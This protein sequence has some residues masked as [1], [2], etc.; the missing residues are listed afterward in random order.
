[1]TRELRSGHAIPTLRFR[2]K[3]LRWFDQHKRDLPWR[4]D[5]NPY[6]IWVSEIMLQQTRVAAVLGYYKRFI[7][8]F[9]TFERLAAAKQSSVLAAWSGLGYYRRAR[10]LHAAAKEIVYE[11]SGRFPTTAV[12]LQTLPGVGRYTSA[13]I[14][15]IAFN[16]PAAVVDGNV[17]RVLQRVLGKNID[18]TNLWQ[19]AEDLLSRRRPGDFNQAM[20]E[21]GATL[22]LPRRPKCLLCPISNICITRGEGELS[23]ASRPNHQNKRE[24]C[25]ALD[26]RNGSV[27]LVKRNKT[28]ELMPEMWELPEIIRASGPV[29]AC[30]TLGHSITVTN[31][32]VHVVR[33]ELP[34]ETEGCWVPK[35]RIT[36]LP[37]TGLTQKILRAAKVI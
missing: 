16:E 29:N 11:R 23:R 25:Y 10:M 2:R 26:C 20:M 1:M 18:S 19:M 31:Y 3:L 15:S 34:A 22:C 9:P 12:E 7:R 5:R 33:C 13:A 6:H 32:L 37:L 28:A 14:A 4:K 30:L 35:S 21:L 27:F 8:R 24:I 17:Q 36:R